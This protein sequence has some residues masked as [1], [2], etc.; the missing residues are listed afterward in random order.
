MDSRLKAQMLALLEEAYEAGRRAGNAETLSAI[1]AAA[2]APIDRRSTSSTKTQDRPKDQS[3]APRGLL[4]QSIKAI[5]QQNPGLTEIELAAQLEG[6]DNGVSPRSAGG[7]LRRMRDKLYRQDG[8]RWFL[9][10][11]KSAGA[12]G[13]RKP[14]DLL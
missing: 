6:L 11:S 3:R 13:D 2:K 8:N 14:A 1:M 12:V 4:R 7:E 5:L 9:L 10:E